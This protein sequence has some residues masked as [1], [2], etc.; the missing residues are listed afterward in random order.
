MVKSDSSF[1]VSVGG[2][3]ITGFRYPTD[4][5]GRELA[6]NELALSRGCVAVLGGEEGAAAVAEPG[7]R[8]LDGEE[9][10]R[11]GD[12]N[13]VGQTQSGSQEQESGG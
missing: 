12:G 5:A 4:D 8:R 6:A 10:G 11:R 3:W 2:A 13:E 9:A 7:Q 1:R